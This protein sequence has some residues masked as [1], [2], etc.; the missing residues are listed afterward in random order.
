[1]KI[2]LKLFCIIFTVSLLRAQDT[3]KDRGIIKK[4][5]DNI[6]ESTVYHFVDLSSGK[7]YSSNNEIPPDAQV[8][9]KSTFEEWHYTNGVINMAMI[10]LADFLGDKK[11][12]DYTA[13]HIAF[14]MDNYKFFQ[15]RYMKDIPYYNYPLGQLWTMK[16]LDDCGAMGAS[17]ID[18]YQKIKRD[19][20]LEYI[21]KAANHISKVQ[22]RLD[23]GTLARK[24]PHKM[25]IWADDLFMSVP[26]LAR[27]GKLNG[28]RKYWDDAINQVL[29]FTKYLW[30]ENAQ[31][32]YHC[33]YA[34][35]KRNGVA[36]WGR[37]NGWVMM[38]QVQLLNQ[39][40]KDYPKRKMII[41]YLERQILGVA[42]YQGGNG[43]WH[44]ILDKNDSYFET[45]CSA[46]FIYCIA[47]AVNQGWIDARYG[48][49]AI[50]GWE[51]LLSNKI[52]FDGQVKDICVGTGIEDNMAFYYN[53]PAQLNDKHG[54]GSVID[55]GIEI[56]KLKESMGKNG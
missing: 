43:L 35:L 51:G 48:S 55:A 50:K 25:T 20:Y 36:H 33:Y 19:D 4:I 52:T 47:R 21:E 41:K 40:P 7:E 24:F 46:M 1:M 53:R 45:S 18:I 30:D 49:I 22:S 2:I 32:Y 10:N 5:A 28:D 8:R 26:F 12:F 3:E 27:I 9:L 31:L 42:K 38:A 54:L 17:M 29:N 56:I 16:E 6:I 11:Y 23:D 13:K 15:A 44:Q 14:G 37:C 39:L 34:D